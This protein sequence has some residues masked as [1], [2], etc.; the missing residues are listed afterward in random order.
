M[1]CYLDE[2]LPYKAAPIAARSGV[3]VITTRDC[4]RN[5]TT[6]EEQL[7][8]ATKLGRV[9]VTQDYKDFDDLAT[10]FIA[11]GRTHAGV[12]FLPSSISTK[13]FAGIAAAIVRYD[14]EHPNGMAPNM[15]DYLVPVR[16]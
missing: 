11:E 7:L 1:P 13:D 2:D 16:Q 12:L 10:R 5:G 3:D 8:F 4:G 14:R 9:L 15:V 6:D